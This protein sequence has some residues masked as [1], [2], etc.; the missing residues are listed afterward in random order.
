MEYIHKHSSRTADTLFDPPEATPVEKVD[1]YGAWMGTHLKAISKISQHA[2]EILDAALKDVEEHDG[3]GHHFRSKVL[4]LGISG[5]GPKV[6]SF[7][8]LLLQPMTS[9]LATIDTHMMD[10]L[11]H[12]YEK[13]MNNR[14]YFKFEREL[15]AGRDAAGYSHVPLGAFQ[16]GMWDHKR[17][18]PGSHQDHSAMR[19][20]DPLDHQSVDWE[21]KAQNLKGLSWLEQ[22]PDWWR[23]TQGARDAVAQEWDER[24]APSFAQNAIPYQL[25]GDPRTAS[26]FKEAGESEVEFHVG[27]DL[28]E[29]IYERLAE[30]AGDLKIKQEKPENYHMTAF[31]SEAGYDD[32]ELHEWIR[33]RS[34][35]GIHFENARLDTFP[36][37]EGGYAAV[38]RFDSPQGKELAGKLMDEGEDRGLDIRR[39]PG[40]W[41]AHITIGWSKE[42]IEPQKFPDLEFRAGHLYVSI[43]R[44]LRKQADTFSKGFEYWWN[45]EKP[46]ELHNA[47]K[48][49]EYAVGTKTKQKDAVEFIEKHKK[50]VKGDFDDFK[51]KFIDKFKRIKLSDL[52]DP[53]PSVDVHRD[54][55][56]DVGAPG[57]THMQFIRLNHPHLTTPEIW[58]LYGDDH[59]KKVG[60]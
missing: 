20:L 10:V 16:W 49:A 7:A 8:W 35:S 9:Q 24:I 60:P 21:T 17:T 3:K 14:D 48:M 38:I 51:K 41:K 55:E 5:V 15:A 30:I 56:W 13:E 12:D 1:R 2:D 36:W 31:W 22:A 33:Q 19:V 18:G 40:G 53:S 28:P 27:F 42:P 46:H 4:N 44:P 26:V 45:K 32:R 11:G 58:K 23:N 59:V 57:E 39:F 37:H 34:V 29:R 6:C 47:A 52:S 50:D 54:G 43:P 25:T